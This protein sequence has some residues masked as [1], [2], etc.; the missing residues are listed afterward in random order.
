[1][2]DLR[3]PKQNAFDNACYAFADSENMEQ[4]AK[5]CGINPTILRNKLNPEQPHKLTVGE[6][7]A[8]T[9][10]SGNYCII[11]S[12]LLS[13]NMVGAR[14]DLNADQETLIK[15]ALENS[16]HAGDLSRLALANGGEIRL[17]RSKRNELL[18]KAHKSVSNL[19]LLMND[20]E[21]ETSGLSPFLSM[22]LDFV[23]NG[24]PIPGLS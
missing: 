3:E 21:N 15:R 24:A 14:V 5:R 6:L 22:S 8:I 4:V 9:E 1:M 19:V 20:L 17:P 10:E 7:V 23:V 12:L 18:D 2:C 16:V 13:L 11:N